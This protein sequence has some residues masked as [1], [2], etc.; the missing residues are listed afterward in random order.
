MGKQ[1]FLALPCRNTSRNSSFVL[2]AVE[3]VLLV[4]RS[5]IGIA[6]G[7]RDIDPKLGGEIEKRRNPLGRMSLENRGI[8]ID[9]KAGR[10][11]RP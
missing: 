1:P 9:L 2:A 5:L 3:E 4:R 10:L 8:G 7:D 11:G 6:R